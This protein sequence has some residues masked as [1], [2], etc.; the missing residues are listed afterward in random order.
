M[1]RPQEQIF[2]LQE[3][4]LKMSLSKADLKET[5]REVI[6]EERAEKE[7]LDGLVSNQK[8]HKEHVVSCPNCYGAII[9]EM[10]KTSDYKC[11]DCGLPLGNKEFIEKLEKCPNCGSEEDAEYI[12]RDYSGNPI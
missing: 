9:D 3:G 12:E 2:H 5:I 7:K 4:D 8:S 10:N 1:P 6:R 11:V